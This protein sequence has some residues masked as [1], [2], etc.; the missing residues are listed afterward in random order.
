[1][2]SFMLCLA[3]SFPVALRFCGLTAAVLGLASGM[4]GVPVDVEQYSYIY[5]LF[6]Y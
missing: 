2:F 6:R 5:R 4:G 1:M 3:R